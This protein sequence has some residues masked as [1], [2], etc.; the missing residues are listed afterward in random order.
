MTHSSASRLQDLIQDLKKELKGDFE[1]VVLALMTPSIEY[2]ARE[3]KHAIKGKD[4]E[5]IVQILFSCEPS[6]VR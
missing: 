6:A 1:D 4:G 3:L 5:A 2:Q